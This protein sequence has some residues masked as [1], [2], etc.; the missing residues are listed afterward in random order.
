MNLSTESKQ[1]RPRSPAIMIPDGVDFKARMEKGEKISVPELFPLKQPLEIEIGCGKGKFALQRAQEN[2]GINILAFDKLWKFLK[3]RKV[4]ADK[5]ELSNLIY[6]K[7]EARLFLEKAVPDKAVSIF[8]LYF[9]DPWP[10]RKHHERRTFDLDFLKLVWQKTVS[11]GFFEIAT[12]FEDYY[13]VMKKVIGAQKDWKLTRE[14]VN[15]RFFAP[16]CLTNY[17]LK[18]QAEGRKLHYIELQKN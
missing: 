8:H 7:A 2:P 3:R 17:E 1:T 11:G 12:D 14:T 10:K 5:Q 4:N 15:E 16:T 18:Y 6:F 9:P 13:Q